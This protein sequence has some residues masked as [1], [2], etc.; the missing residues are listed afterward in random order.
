MNTN[1]LFGRK[2]RVLVTLGVVA[3]LLSTTSALAAPGWLDLTFG[4]NGIA[5]TDLESDS[6]FG[7]DIALQS[8]GKILMLV[9]AQGE[10]MPVL[11]RYNSNGSVDN[12]FGAGGKLTLD[13]GFKV[14]LQSDGKL[15]VAGSCN[16]GI[17]V[18]RYNSN[19]TNLD[20][21][22]GTDGVSI[23]SDENGFS[24]YSVSDLAIES[25]GQIVVVG[26]ESNQGNFTNIVL[27]RFNSDGAQDFIRILDKFDFPNNRYNNGKAVAIQPNGKIIVSG[28]MM[29]DD[30]NDQI[31]LARLNQNGSLDTST[32]GTN[33]K[34]TVMAPLS[35][36]AH[37][38]GAITLQTDGKIVVVGTIINDDGTVEDLAVARFNAN[39]ALDTTFGGTGIVIT[40]FGAN[41][42]GAD[43]H[44][45]SDGRIVVVGTSS[46]G[47]SGSLLLVRYNK[48]GSLDNTFGDNGKLLGGLGDGSSSG[49]GI[50][51]QPNGKLVVAGAR[52]GV[53]ILARYNAVVPISVTSTFK[54]AGAYDGWILES[55]E[56]SSVGG[57]V[58]RIATTF[59]VGDDLRDRQYRGIISF[60][61]STLPDTAVVTSARLSIRKQGVVGTDPLTTHGDLLVD[62]RNSAFSRNVVL[63]AA[64]FSAAASPGA[65]QERI[66]TKPANNW[67][68]VNLSSP[69]LRFISKVG[70]TQFRLLFGMDDNDDLGADYLKFF[71]GNAAAGNQPRLIVTYYTP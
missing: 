63:Q 40:D 38:N 19:G 50:E 64:D 2:F 21:T 41:E 67:Y 13:F 53:A 5:V 24:R 37:S 57:A 10:Q 31:S 43:I 69:N 46:T 16:G 4:T 55:G 34:G 32:F 28:N 6:R 66:T 12:T 36:F 65:S 70:V 23:I 44:L 26:T 1:L 45:Q 18:A 61:T 51:I 47:D 49:A 11:L 8:D 29:D 68:T 54:S 27:A 3:M 42:H 58:D 25:D 60:N 35:D 9:P 56:N 7:S 22:F 20:N 59:N 48:D 14:S 33:G 71:T 52:N 15:V 62:I 30:A 39:G 17:A